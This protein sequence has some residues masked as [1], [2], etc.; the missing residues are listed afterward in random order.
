MRL[1]LKLNRFVIFMVIMI[2]SID[3]NMVS[4]VYVITTNVVQNYE[5]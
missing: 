5:R 2:R 1:T 3:V 4:W